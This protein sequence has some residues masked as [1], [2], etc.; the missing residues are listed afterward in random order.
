MVPGTSSTLVPVPS[1]CPWPP[2]AAPPSASTARPV[3]SAS[4][5]L[6]RPPD[7]PW[8]EPAPS[9]LWLP[10]WPP[11]PRPTPL[12]WPWPGLYGVSPTAPAPRPT[13]WPP[14]YPP[15]PP[16]PPTPS[17]TTA[18]PPWGPSPTPAPEPLSDPPWGLPGRWKRRAPRPAVAAT[19]PPGFGCFCLRPGGLGRPGGSRPRAGPLLVSLA[20]SCGTPECL[21]S[22]ARALR[23]LGAAPA[24]RRALGRAG[25][26]RALA[27]RLATL[28][29]THPACLALARALRGLTDSPG[30][31]ADDVAPA[32]PALAALAAHAKRDHRQPALGAIANAC[33][34]APLRPALGAAGAV[35]AVA[36]EVKR[37]LASPNNTNGVAGATVAVR[38]LCL[39]CR[40]AVN[41]ARVR[42]AGGL[43]LLLRL[44]AE[45][46]ARPW[47]PRVLLALAAFAYDQEA[48]AALEARG[49]VPLLADVLRA[50][51]DEE[52]EEE[53]EE[54]EEEE[55]EEE[56]EA[57]ASCDLPRELPGPPGPGAA[58]GSLRGLKSWLLSEAVSPPPS[59]PPPTTPLHCPSP[60][61]RRLPPMGALALPQGVGE[62]LLR[63]LGAAAA[64]PF[65][66]GLLTHMLRC[67]APPAR[68]GCAT[69]LP[70]LTRS[71][72]LSEA[73]S[74]PPSPPPPT[75]PLHC[76]S[77]PR[78]RLPPMGA[79]ALPQGVGE[80]DPWLPEAPALLLLGR[81]AA[82]DEP[83]RALAT[84]PVVSGLLRYLTGVPAPAPRA[85]RLLQRLTGHPAF[86]GALVRAYVPSLLR[87]GLLRN[88]GAAAAAP[89]GVGLLTHML[90]CGAPPARLAC[91]TALPLL[92][93]PTS[94]ARGLLW[95]GG[96]VALL[97][98][99]VAQGPAS[100]YE[101]PPAF[102][103][104]AADAISLLRGHAGD[105]PGDTGHGK[106]TPGQA[107][108]ED[109]QVHGDE[110][111]K[112]LWGHGDTEDLWGQ[113]DRDGD[114]GDA[115][116]ENGDLQRPLDQ[117][118]D[119]EDPWGHAD[120]FRDAEDT[121]RHVDGDTTSPVDGHGDIGDTPGC[122]NGHGDPWGH[123]NGL[124][125]ADDS[126]GSTGSPYP[127]SP[128]TLYP[129][130]LL[131]PVSPCPQ[132]SPDSFSPGSP[133]P[134]VSPRAA[135]RSRASSCPQLSPDLPDLHSQVAPRPPKRP[136]LSSSP[137]L[138]SDLPNSCPQVSLR[139]SNPCPQLSP[140]P[141][142]SPSPLGPCP[143]P[144][145]VSS[146]PCPQPSPCPQASPTSS[147]PSPPPSPAPQASPAT[148]AV[149]PPVSPTC[150]YAQTPHDLLLL[151]NG[152]HPGV[153]VARA[154]LIQ[155]SPVLGAMLGGAFA[156]AHQAAVTLGCAPR[157]PLLLLLHF[158][159][160][161]RGG[162]GDGCPLLSPPVS[163]ATAGAAVALA[164]R[165]LVE[166][167]EGVMATAVTAS[168]A[169]LWALAERWASTPL[170]NR[171]AQAILGGP[172]HNVAPR[173]V[174]VARL[175][176]CPP[177]LARA[178]MA[179]VAPQGARP[180]LDMGEPWGGGDPLLRP[181]GDTN[182]DLRDVQED[183]R[184]LEGDF[185]VPYE[186]LRDTQGDL[187]NVADP[188]R[189]PSVD[190]GDP[191]GEDDVDV[192]VKG[193]L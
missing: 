113:V 181:P 141:Q 149:H 58:T 79:L 132:V 12:A 40:E 20:A 8:D 185:G 62:G 193:P 120:T 16:W 2:P 44:L 30:P 60:P 165:Y 167:F 25:A 103:L 99:A 164:R 65:G 93:R 133:C 117:H 145:P 66:V 154:A 48:L 138:S 171:A 63:N 31:S 115:L 26:I 67:G 112:D 158:I 183:L 108:A 161:C 130:P 45:P 46:R 4:W 6:P 95:G 24:P 139:F 21:H 116:E 109:L 28:S 102:A 51:A 174:R 140:S 78:R 119:L 122:T 92:T 73:V 74:P 75:T 104:Y 64:A 18:S 98:S 124:G 192:E 166:G 34:R 127:L 105:T 87:E 157:H 68:L 80:G 106:D 187:D 148:P 169:A 131:S 135:K 71:W 23:I 163:P 100:P 178:L 125:D 180:H 175:A 57:A 84:A 29:P 111:T 162:S 146:S 81:L 186:D 96:A 55:E 156:E 129:P 152:G 168:P 155:G 110:D 33:A 85:A 88:L 47:R 43:G 61:R 107:D 7:E 89:F 72:L 59:P 153:P 159:H 69:A 191:L 32:L 17:G 3:P 77:P 27:S 142:G 42:A 143:Q 35:E 15:W 36:E 182:G 128:V 190:S 184:D 136:L 37:A 86:L 22:A 50:R 70:L 76:P 118:K 189:D 83:S 39:L 82:A 94:P 170:A 179:A 49:L 54:D 123:A 97:L 91:A 160:G 137:P 41:R 56:D 19:R 5:G 53:E 177:R 14:L 173:L 10:A 126:W 13:T 150:P 147:S 1:W 38:A 134:Q 9:E 188:F 151:P 101:P 52:E 172:P 90:R 176:R 114:S 11:S 121:W 144:S